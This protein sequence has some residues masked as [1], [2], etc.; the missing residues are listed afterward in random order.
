MVIGGVLQPG[1]KITAGLQIKEGP[2]LLSGGIPEGG[3][4]NNGD[5]SG[6]SVAGGIAR[7]DTLG[8]DTV[9]AHGLILPFFAW[10][11]VLDLITH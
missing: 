4:L 10:V 7:V 9:L 8:T 1:I 5:V 6:L 3:G 11:T 2:H